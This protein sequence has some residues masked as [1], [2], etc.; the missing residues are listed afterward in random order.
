MRMARA[1]D[2]AP[3]DSYAPK[4]SHSHPSRQPPQTERKLEP[5]EDMGLQIG[6]GVSNKGKSWNFE[7]SRSVTHP[8]RS[9]TC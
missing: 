2:P 9:L 3:L 5:K 4:H 8:L 6:R 7:R 1:R